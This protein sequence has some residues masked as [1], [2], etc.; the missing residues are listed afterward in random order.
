MRKGGARHAAPGMHAALVSHMCRCASLA[1]AHAG[2]LALTATIRGTQMLS[3]R[4]SSSGITWRQAAKA[5]GR[6]W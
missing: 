2:T 4:L 1:H 6:T 5:V 3:R